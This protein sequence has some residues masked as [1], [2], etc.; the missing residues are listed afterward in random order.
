MDD[1]IG[2][3]LITLQ[4][5]QL[6]ISP[7]RD[8]CSVYIFSNCGKDRNRHAK[9][10]GSGRVGRSFFKFNGAACVILHEV[11]VNSSPL[12]NKESKRELLTA[13]NLRYTNGCNVYV[14][15]ATDDDA[16]R[17]ITREG[18]VLGFCDIPI[19][20][21]RRKYTK[22]NF[23][24]SVQILDES[25]GECC[26]IIN[27]ISPTQLS[28]RG[29]KQDDIIKIEDD[30]EIERPVEFI[31]IR[32]NAKC[33]TGNDREAVDE[34]VE[35]VVNKQ[36]NA[37]CPPS[38]LSQEKNRELLS[39]QSSCIPIESNRIEEDKGACL[40][41]IR[42][43]SST[44]PEDNMH[45]TNTA[46]TSEISVPSSATLFLNKLSN[47]TDQTSI[48]NF[49]LA[50]V[51]VIDVDIRLDKNGHSKG[52]AFVT[53]SQKDAHTSLEELKGKKLNGNYIR[54]SYK[55]W[56]TI[57]PR[58]SEAHVQIK[59]GKKCYWCMKCNRGQ[60]LWTDHLERDHGEDDCQPQNKR[61]RSS[62]NES[63]EEEGNKSQ[64]DMPLNWK[65]LPP[66]LADSYTKDVDG[67]KYL[68]CGDRKNDEGKWVQQSQEEHREI[69]RPRLADNRSTTELYHAKDWRD[70]SSIITKNEELQHSGEKRGSYLV[71]NKSRNRYIFE[72]FNDTTRYYRFGKVKKAMR[73]KLPPSIWNSSVPVCLS[74][75][76]KGSCNSSCGSAEDHKPLNTHETKRL[77][78]W[79]ESHGRKESSSDQ[80]NESKW[81]KRRG[82][83][84][85]VHGEEIHAHFEKHTL[86]K[87][88]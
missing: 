24:Y 86:D 5:N 47:D 70:D 4:K 26:E 22:D 3:D 66:R 78:D 18:V 87:I 36:V 15:Q 57:A 55:K 35:R 39:S 77:A 8:K 50:V 79:F 28:F 53:M 29:S 73:G 54:M 71:R 84:F 88:L 19:N 13:D 61:P 44:H 16:K 33:N 46:R 42:P 32:G 67:K 43:I 65:T 48:K 62:N 59:N 51:E 72:R 69:K 49:F 7:F 76:I 6:E 31:H 83:S 17:N 52:Y 2:R 63:T 30:D 1:L 9:V 41:E 20:D 12:T 81:E 80:R 58:E 11:Y 45:L 14:K 23:W 38:T 75:H 10:I 60:G 34:G 21:G 25:G 40:K 64:I 56:W 74:F 85:V 68:W 37:G 27:E 82:S